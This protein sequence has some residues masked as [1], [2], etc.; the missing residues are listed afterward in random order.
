[1][2]TIAVLLVVIGLVLLFGYRQWGWR[3]SG[4]IDPRAVRAVLRQHF[5]YYQRLSPDQQQ[6]FERR[7]IRFVR[8]KQFIGR[9]MEVALPMQVLVA[10]AAVQLTF[11]LPE[12][13]LQHFKRILIYPDNYYSTITQ[14]YHKG[15]VNPAARAIVLSWKNFTEGYAQSDDSLN[16]GL[17]EMAHALEIENMVENDE[18]DFLPPAVWEQWQEQAAAY[19]NRMNRAGSDFFRAYAATNDQEFFAIAVENFFERPAEFKSYAPELYDTLC[20]L[21]RQDPTKLV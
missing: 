21:L 17:H 1:M 13:V 16:L 4:F 5:A 20:Q 14:Q 3:W 8:K 19:R 18:Y 15:E 7:V 9:G 11:G 10:A 12:L 2:E 6:E